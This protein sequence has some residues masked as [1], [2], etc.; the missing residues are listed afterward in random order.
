MKVSTT[1]KRLKE[2]MELFD[3]KQSDIVKRTGMN[4]SSLSNYIS[5]RRT[6]TQEQI[7]VIADPYGINPAWLMGYDVDISTL[8]KTSDRKKREEMLRQLYDAVEYKTVMDALSPEERKEISDFILQLAKIPHESR[9]MILNMLRSAV[10]H[11]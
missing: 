3:L 9:Q 11:S 5:G 2:F 6:P 1:Q 7:S 10:P 8:P 4:K